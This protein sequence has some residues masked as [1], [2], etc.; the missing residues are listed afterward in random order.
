MQVELDAPEYQRQAHAPVPNAPHNRERSCPLRS[1]LEDF[2]QWKGNDAEKWVRFVEAIVSDS[3]YNCRILP[4]PYKLLGSRIELL[5]GQQ[6]MIEINERGNKHR[7]CCSS[8]SSVSC[9]SADD[10]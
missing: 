2:V 9:I 4:I 6:T 1:V 8:S 3:N 5:K 7:G 10:S